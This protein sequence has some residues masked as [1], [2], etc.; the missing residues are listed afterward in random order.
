MKA[1]EVPQVPEWGE[2]NK[3]RVVEFLHLFDRQLATSPFAAGDRYT[4]ADIT[5]LVAID[6]MKPAKIAAGRVRQRAALV[7]RGQRAA[8]HRCVTPTCR[9]VRSDSTYPSA[10]HPFSGLRHR[11]DR[12]AR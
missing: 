5:R 7:C 8:E 12:S 4:I 1:L 2:A 11:T 3:P 6:L 9:V 10:F